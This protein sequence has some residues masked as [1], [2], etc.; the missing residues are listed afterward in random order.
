MHRLCKHE[1]GKGVLRGVG[2]GWGGTW[3]HKRAS[4]AAHL[5]AGLGLLSAKPLTAFITCHKIM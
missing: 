2:W 1:G 3:D 4:R 5:R